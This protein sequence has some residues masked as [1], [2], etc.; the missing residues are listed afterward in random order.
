MKRFFFT[1]AVLLMTLATLTACGDRTGDTDGIT[2]VKYDSGTGKV[3]ITATLTS[4]TYKKYKN[5]TLYIM[6]IP[7]GQFLRDVSTSVPA[8]QLKAKG[9]MEYSLDL[10]SGA[11]TLLYSGFVLARYDLA[12]GYTPVGE[13]RYVENPEALATSTKAYP[14]FV[15]QKG[16]FVT[17]AAQAVKTGTKHTII[18]VPVE[19]YIRA[20]GDDETLATIFCGNTY[21]INRAELSRLD[22]KVKTMSEAGIEVILQFTLDTSPYELDGGIGKLASVYTSGGSAPEGEN[23]HY[24][25]AV[26]DPDCFEKLASFFEYLAERYTREDG[27]Y[28]FAGAFIIGDGVND[29]ESTNVDT[30]RTLA[31]TTE[32][33]AR[34]LRIAY[35]ALRSKYANGKIFVSVDSNWTAENNTGATTEPA[36]T[37]ASDEDAAEQTPNS[38]E[39]MP[40]AK[41]RRFGSKEFLSNLAARLLRGGDIAYSVCLTLLDDGDSDVSNDVSEGGKTPSSINC[42]NLTAVNTFLNST[43]LTYG[44]ERRELIVIASLPAENEEKMAESYAK[45]FFACHENAVSAFIY[46]GERDG[47]TGN[48]ETGLM[49]SGGDGQKPTQRSIYE[50][51]T[52]IDRAGGAAILSKL[53]AALGEM[54]GNYQKEKDPVLHLTGTGSSSE[55]KEKRTETTALFSFDGSSV[56]GFYP[57]YNALSLEPRGDGKDASI[58]ATLSPLGPGDLAGVRSPEI[59]GERFARGRTIKL[60]LEADSPSSNTSR[61]TLF[62]SGTGVDGDVSYLSE[63]IVQSGNRQTVYFD[64]S[65]FADEIGDEDTVRLSVWCEADNGAPVGDGDNGGYALSIYGIELTS[66]KPI[67]PL[68]WIIPLILVLLTGGFFFVTRGIPILSTAISNYR[69]NTARERAMRQRQRRAEGRQGAIPG[70]SPGTPSAQGSSRQGAPSAQGSSRQGAPSTRRPSANP[71]RPGTRPRR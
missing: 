24:A 42:G 53:S 11:R 29:L 41:R 9:T 36:D 26:S 10:K 2:K 70:R 30:E 17:S 43:G 67:S 50:I 5:E 13:V 55:Q 61:V 4:D 14:T 56:G 46:N 51:Y 37:A 38:S 52:E 63:A 3:S 6:E 20:K 32:S 35:T 28:G 71:P 16:L 48:G 44:D 21:Y 23:K 62:L 27:E 49:T 66:K 7:A 68:V 31:E 19:K 57:A 54:A 15:S 8:A 39:N 58:C 34:L 60:V 40:V 45:L 22:H 12:E 64:I 47:M 25:L 59:S 33:Y 65:E 18:R 1:L 69:E